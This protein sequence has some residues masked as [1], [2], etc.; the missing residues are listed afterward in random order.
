MDYTKKRIA[1]FAPIVFVTAC[2]GMGWTHSF[3]SQSDLN[4]DRY[5]CEQN[6]AKMYPPQLSGSNPTYNTDCMN[7]G[8]GYTSC[9]TNVSQPLQ[10]DINA[11]NRSIAF[12]SCMEAQGWK[13][14]WGL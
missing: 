12:S 14:S 5:Q 9:T 2:A 3:K 4:R 6:T 7:M 11:N 10:H 13:W 1:I 8:G